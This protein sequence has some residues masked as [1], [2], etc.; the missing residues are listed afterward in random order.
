MRFS[1]ANIWILYLIWLVPLWSLL[2]HF[3]RRRQQQKRLH[4]TGSLL[5]GKLLPADNQRLLWFQ[6]LALA[7]ALF[8]LLLAAAGPRSTR[9]EEQK[10]AI[11]GRDIVLLLDV[12]RSMLADDVRPSRLVRAKADM[13]DILDELRPG[14]RVA[15]VAFRYR[16]TRITPFTSD[17]GFLRQAI[18]GVSID[19]APA[20]ETDIGAGIRMA[21]DIFD[22]DTPSHKAII[23][24]SDGEDLAGEAISA[25]QDAARRNIP[26]FTVGIGSRTGSTIPDRDSPQGVFLFEGEPVITRLEDESLVTLARLTGGAYI[27]VETAGA[28]AIT[29]GQR[30]REQLR[31]V[32]A[33][34]YTTM[35]ASDYTEL[36]SYFLLPAIVLLLIAGFLTQ[37]P[38]RK[39][40]RIQHIAIIMLFFTGA[41]F[42][43]TGENKSGQSHRAIARQA[44]HLQQ[45]NQFTEAAQLY[46]RAADTPDIAARLRDRYRYNAAIASLQAGDT[47]TAVNLL[48]RLPTIQQA[49]LARA[50]AAFEQGRSAADGSVEGYRERVSQWQEAAQRLQR[51][52]QQTAEAASEEDLQ[53]LDAILPQ[54]AREAT[55]ADI[56]ERYADKD[57]AQLA[58]D[59]MQKQRS[60]DDKWKSDEIPPIGPAR[61]E[62]FQNRARERNELAE[63]Y[64]AL[65]HLLQS[66]GIPPEQFN[67][68]LD[69]QQTL[70]EQVASLEDLS[71]L[72]DTHLAEIGHPLY[73]AWRERGSPESMLTESLRQQEWLD[74]IAR[75]PANTTQPPV[76]L[77]R[78]Q[79]EAANLTDTFAERYQPPPDTDPELIAEM[80]TLTDDAARLQRL[81]AEMLELDDIE[82]A[83]TVQEEARDKLRRL[84]EIL[85][86]PPPS[87]SEDRED[88]DDDPTDT[89]PPPPEG[90]PDDEE[91]DL[92]LPPPPEPDDQMDDEDPEDEPD[93][94]EPEDE[95]D[96]TFDVDA[97]LEQVEQRSQEYQE[98]LD[99]RRRRLQRQ[100][101][102]RDW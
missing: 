68:L 97:M 21:L 59:M 34:T 52:W 91:S 4:F 86:K 47:E 24:L 100:E 26:F 85:P 101:S 14:D 41:A 17:Q 25:A 2:L 20:G 83:R 1:F 78:L 12:S 35:E 42:G 58:W 56:L 98:L 33:R 70:E 67:R 89:P 45:Q 46:L 64:L 66:D 11:R 36:F 9:P 30:I 54:A 60:Q 8:F 77:S 18:A 65:A 75:D 87:D 50:I 94:P 53:K 57:P 88:Q 38:I 74:A 15:I 39:H 7:G 28:G 13:F 84:S 73:D 82:S 16:A 51:H 40:A 79:T 23:L 5:A 32:E 6:E 81:A 27:P 92:Q 95:E 22:D 43:E 29:L 99:E 19:S 71:P 90:E 44:Q 69:E 3:L 10:V 63:Q 96:D 76:P 55:L 80:D 93:D 102:A 31:A 48:E 49:D 37:G 62:H 72:T 61:L